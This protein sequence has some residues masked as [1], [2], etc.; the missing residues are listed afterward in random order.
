MSRRNI[1]LPVDELVARYEAGESTRALGRAHGV[2]GP[3]VSRR[4]H[5]AGVEMRSV[6]APPGNN[7]HHGKHRRGGPLH[8]DRKG[9]LRT[10]D[11]EGKKC[12]VHRACW[13]AHHGP[14]PEGHVVHHVN[15]DRV[16]NRVENLDCMPDAE[17]GQL[18]ARSAAREST[19]SRFT[20]R[21]EGLEGG[22]QC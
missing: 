3:T 2:S 8:T 21:G 5:A 4:L 10:Y 9:Y 1:R 16:D 15:E 13:E 22:N 11:R 6:G 7:Y 14:I 12:A 20:W 17:H 19:S 18:H